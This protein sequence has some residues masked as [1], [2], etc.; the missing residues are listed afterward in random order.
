MHLLIWR[1]YNMRSDYL[2]ENSNHTGSWKKKVITLA[3]ENKTLTE[4]DSGKVFFVNQSAAY[5]ITLPATSI[6]GWNAKFIITT[7]A[8]N[9]VDIVAGTAD[10]MSGTEISNTCVGFTDVDKVTFAS[11]ASTVGD[12]VEVVSDGSKMYTTCVSVA[13]GGATSAG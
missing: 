13:A 5:D 10:T 9:D 11:G 8:S 6:A 3:A 12:Y 2:N 7:A 1:A 4:A